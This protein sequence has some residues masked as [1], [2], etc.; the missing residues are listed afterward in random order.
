MVIHHIGSSAEV[1]EALGDKASAV[2]LPRAADGG[3]W[4]YF[5]DEVQRDLLRQQEQGGR[6]PLDQLP[7]VG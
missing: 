7:V 1:V 4:T 2:P 3:G 5:G 6:V